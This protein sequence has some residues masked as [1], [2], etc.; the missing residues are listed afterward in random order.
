MV[1]NS[2]GGNCWGQEWRAHGEKANF[3]A[4]LKEG[5]DYNTFYSGKYLNT[6]GVNGNLTPPPDWDYWAGLVGN[7][8][9][10]NYR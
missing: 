3:G 1:N 9:Y 10:Y 2:F 5:A 4:L 7:S 6:Y 8:K